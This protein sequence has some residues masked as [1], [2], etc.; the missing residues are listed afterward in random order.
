MLVTAHK[1]VLWGIKLNGISDYSI[2]NERAEDMREVELDYGNHKATTSSIT[3]HGKSSTST[4]KTDIVLRAIF[5]R[6][7]AKAVKS[8]LST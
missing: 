1:A 6:R 3:G 8:F 5:R 7:W 4:R 2:R